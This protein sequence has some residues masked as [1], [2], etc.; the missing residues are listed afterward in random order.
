LLQLSDYDAF[1]LLLTGEVGIELMSI[2]GFKS[3]SRHVPTLIHAD[4]GSWDLII[5]FM[6][7]VISPDLDVEHV[8]D[9]FVLLFLYEHYSEDDLH[10]TLWENMVFSGAVYKKVVGKDEPEIDCN[11]ANLALAFH[12]SHFDT[13]QSINNGLYPKLEGMAEGN[14]A[15]GTERRADAARIM[16]KDYRKVC[17]MEPLDQNR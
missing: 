3:W 16:M 13:E 17:F 7:Q 15:E 1:P 4:K 5:D 10:I 14:V 8:T 9:M 6:I 11:K 12:L 2:D